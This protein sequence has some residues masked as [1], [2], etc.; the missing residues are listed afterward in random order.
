MSKIIG[1]TPRGR[2]DAIVDATDAVLMSEVNVCLVEAGDGRTVIG[3]ELA[4]RVNMSTSHS[5]LLYLMDEEGVASIISELL[6]LA[7]RAGPDLQA[8]LRRR[9]LG[10]LDAL[11]Q[12]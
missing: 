4:G 11:E 12:L 2:N 3:L 8:S 1:G 10:R 7:D 9:L 5:E 6:A